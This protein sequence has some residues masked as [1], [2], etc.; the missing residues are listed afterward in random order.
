MSRLYYNEP[1]QSIPVINHSYAGQWKPEQ[2]EKGNGL[3]LEGNIEARSKHIITDTTRKKYRYYVL[4]L[5]VQRS[6]RR[7]FDSSGKEIE[8]NFSQTKKVQTG[9]LQSTYKVKAKGETDKLSQEELE[10]VLKKPELTKLT[11]K[12]TPPGSIPFWIQEENLEKI[13]LTDGEHIRL[14]TSG[15]GPFIESIT[16]IDFESVNVCNYAGGQAVG[17]SW[18]DKIMSV[19]SQDNP[20]TQKGDEEGAG[21]DD[22]EWDD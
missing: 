17:G 22:D 8:P 16:K 9:Y 15:D 13:D 21:A 10:S 7:Q 18:T 12:Q 14:K 4:H 5:K 20:T 2:Y 1:L 6:H 3:L 19:K 11:E